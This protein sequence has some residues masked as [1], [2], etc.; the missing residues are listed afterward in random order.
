MGEAIRTLRTKVLVA[1][2]LKAGYDSV[3]VFVDTVAVEI[4]LDSSGCPSSKFSDHFKA[5]TGSDPDHYSNPGDKI[6]FAGLSHNHKNV[7]ERNMANGMPGCACE[8]P[9]ISVEYCCC[10]A[11]P[12]LDDTCK[13]SMAKLKKADQDWYSDIVG[14]HEWEILSQDM[15][16]EEPTAAHT[17]ALALNNKNKVALVTGHLEIMRT[18]K[19][20]CKPDPKTLEM[21]YPPVR[22]ALIKSYG[23]VVNDTPFYHAFQLVVLSGGHESETWDDFFT[24]T[25]YYVDERRRQIRPETYSTLVQ[26]CLL[27]TSDAADE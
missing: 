17:I 8:P 11:T 27:Y 1:E 15:D 19:S 18:L 12:I 14:G 7:A 10:N 13:Y 20:L 26:Y 21:P 6:L 22:S 4:D 16:K 9:A 3:E 25:N 5:N 23:S 2:I 24:W